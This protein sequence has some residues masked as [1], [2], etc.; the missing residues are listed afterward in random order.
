MSLFC[1][2]KVS[3]FVLWLGMY[4]CF[5]VPND[6]PWNAPECFQ[7]DESVSVPITNLASYISRY[8][9]SDSLI[10]IKPIDKLVVDG[11]NVSLRVND[12]NMRRFSWYVND[13]KDLQ[14]VGYGSCRIL[15]SQ[16]EVAEVLCSRFTGDSNMSDE[17]RIKAV[18]VSMNE[19]GSFWVEYGGCFCAFVKGKILV[20]AQSMHRRSAISVRRIVEALTE[21]WGL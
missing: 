6:K 4:T 2:K 21:K 14:H 13:A 17:L 19:D 11:T 15:S 10:K 1:V 16:K 7:S 8:P 9:L 18:R 12:E 20:C 5:A 3:V